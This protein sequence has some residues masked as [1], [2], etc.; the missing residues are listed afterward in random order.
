MQKSKDFSQKLNTE[1]L[2]DLASHSWEY[3]QGKLIQK[4]TCIPMFT[5]LH[6]IAKTWK[7]PK[8]DEWTKMTLSLFNGKL[9]SH[10]RE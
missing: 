8:R 7:Q 6:T 3:T 1:L 9:P 5:A 2:Y 10:K 4:D